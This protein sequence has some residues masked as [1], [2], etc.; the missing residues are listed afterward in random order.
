MQTERLTFRHWKDSDAESL[1]KY[2]SDPE[3]GPHA[4][5]P[6][7]ESVEESLE[8]IRTL[9]NSD[10]MWA[11]VLK[12]TDEPI[13]CIGYLLKGNTN[14]SVGDDEAE[15]GY[16]VAR[17]YWNKGLCTEALH[18]MIDYCFSVKR[19][20]I[21][22]GDFFVDNPASGHVMEKCGFKDTGIE[23][24]CPNLYGGADRLVHVKKLV[25]QI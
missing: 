22:W 19:M 6:P 16:W 24:S 2:A 25:R 8:T 3:V 12:E 1:F 20:Q 9:F 7:H 21:L 11:M 13:G 10:T 17:P 18:W 23:T 15:I 14:I 5:W 4:G